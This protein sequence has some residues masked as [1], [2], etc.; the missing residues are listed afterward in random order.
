V[1]YGPPESQAVE[2]LL[3]AAGVAG[4]EPLAGLCPG[5]VWAT[6]RWPTAGYAEVGRR[7][8]G[9]GFRVVLLGG[10]GDV[11]VCSTVAAGI[12]AGVVDAAGRTALKALAAWMDRLAVVVTNDS[13]PLHVA[14]ARGTPTVAIFGA[15]TSA[16]GFG[17]FHAAS[18][19]LEVELP[20]RPCG[21]H[22]GRRCPEGHFRCMTEVTPEQVLGAI[23]ALLGRGP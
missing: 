9:Q 15:T 3:G 18:R 22:G 5:S 20:C 4:E 21:R 1:G 12:G 16:L 23:A 13:A 17:P 8:V 11:E 19:L 7:L 6:K 2:R 14:A 10:P